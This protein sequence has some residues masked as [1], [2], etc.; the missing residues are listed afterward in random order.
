MPAAPALVPL[1]IAFVFICFGYLSD[2]ILFVL[3]LQRR[4]VVIS[5]AALVFNVIG[6]LILVPIFGFMGA[7]WMTLITEIVVLGAGSRLLLR[8]LELPRPKLGRVGRTAIAAGVLA[9]IL[10]A[11]SLASNE[12]LWVLIP[13]ACVLY[14]ALLL[15]LRAVT[16]DEASALVR[17]RQFA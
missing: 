13:A 2:N 17:R 11:L 3:G 15:G 16:L 9:A 5:V 7:A 1:G 6:N 12:S 8:T 14:P 4:L 10:E